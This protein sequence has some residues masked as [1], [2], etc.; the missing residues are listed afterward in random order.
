MLDGEGDDDDDDERNICLVTL[1]Q[2][3]SRP[4]CQWRVYWQTCI[5]IGVWMTNKLFLS[6]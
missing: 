5:I 3:T 2:S 1:F 4:A 6:H